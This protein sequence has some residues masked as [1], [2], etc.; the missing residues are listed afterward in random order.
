[1]VKLTMSPNT[2]KSK[3]KLRKSMMK[4]DHFTNSNNN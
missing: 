3:L 2:K 4:N 1:M